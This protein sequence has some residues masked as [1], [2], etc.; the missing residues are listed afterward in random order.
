MVEPEEPDAFAQLLSYVEQET[1]TLQLL[2]CKSLKECLLTGKANSTRE[3]NPARWKHYKMYLALQNKM[4]AEQRHILAEWERTNCVQDAQDALGLRPA[5]EHFCSVAEQHVDA[6]RAVRKLTLEEVCLSRAAMESSVWG[7][8]CRGLQK[9]TAVELGLRESPCQVTTTP[10]SH[11]L[12]R[13]DAMHQRLPL[14]F[15]IL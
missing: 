7:G 14:M 12:L 6:M 15:S 3:G 10:C 8:V 13:F 1:E 9:K 5:F 2:R 4:S 11:L